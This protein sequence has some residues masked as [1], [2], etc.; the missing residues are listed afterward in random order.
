MMKNI[1]LGWSL[2]SE[3]FINMMMVFASI[4]EGVGLC[5]N[6]HKKERGRVY[7]YLQRTGLLVDVVGG[8]QLPDTSDGC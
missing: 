2:F 5:W 7:P 6:C 4:L 3:S 8:S 1:I